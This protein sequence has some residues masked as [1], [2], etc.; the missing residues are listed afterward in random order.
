MYILVFTLMYFIYM[1]RTLLLLFHLILSA[2]KRIILMLPWKTVG[3]HVP[4]SSSSAICA[5]SMEES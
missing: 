1:H 2:L 4:S 5:P 3:M